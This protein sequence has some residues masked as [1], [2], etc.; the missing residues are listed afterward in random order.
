MIFDVLPSKNVIKRYHAWK[1][2]PADLKEK[3]KGLPVVFGS[4]YQRASKY[5]FYTGQLA[6]SQNFY[7]G[8]K[9][10][11]NFWPIEDS[12]LGKPV[13]M[14]DIYELER[15]PDTLKA[16][17][18]TI[19]YKYEPSFVSFA[20]INIDLKN[21]DISIK[22]GQEITLQCKT[23]M[24]PK[25]SAFINSHQPLLDTVRL[26]VF[27]DKGWIKDIYTGWS[28]QQLA[29]D[30]ET[31]LRLDPA[32]PRGKYY[33]R[34]AINSGGYRPTHNSDKIKLTVK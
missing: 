26:G 27:G 22:E 5:W 1:D 21:K 11:Y 7:Q 28:L 17:V 25:Y 12:L 19:G 29:K 15:F 6:Y 32:L 31:D 18:F 3:T 9:S 2:W 4:S 10:N 23:S 34:F 13:Y 8:R 16:R 14:L 20:K 30:S 33:L 24:P